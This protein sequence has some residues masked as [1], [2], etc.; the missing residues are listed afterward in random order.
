MT[1]VETTAS[2]T[3][4]Q[5]MSLTVRLPGDVL[6]GDHRVVVVIDER[7]AAQPKPGR[8]EDW[9]RHDVGPWPDGLSLRRE[10]L[11]GDFGRCVG[12]ARHDRP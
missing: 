7:V 8:L 3:P 1:T 2:V 11:Y 5:T 6:P 4:Q 12:G 9:P 10:E